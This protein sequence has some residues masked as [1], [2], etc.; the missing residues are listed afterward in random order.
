MGPRPSCLRQ[1]TTTLTARTVPDN[2][3]SRRIL[4]SAGFL[5]RGTVRGTAIRQDVDLVHVERRLDP[6]TGP[7]GCH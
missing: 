2:V 7:V 5:N 6:P 1:W 4:E 3:A